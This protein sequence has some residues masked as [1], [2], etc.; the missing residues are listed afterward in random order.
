MNE[1]KI[2]AVNK[3]LHYF[4][5]NNCNSVFICKANHISGKQMMSFRK[6][7]WSIGETFGGKN[8]LLN[9]FL[10]K[11]FLKKIDLKGSYIAII[12]KDFFETLSVI[13][14]FIKKMN[15][16]KNFLLNFSFFEN[17]FY[18]EKKIK[19]INNYENVL[20]VQIEFIHSLNALL[21]KFTNLLNFIKN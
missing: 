10:E 21:V 16:N 2:N 12:S 18:D 11:K 20:H 5:N 15:L 3:M 1:E 17:Y 14:S 6:N 7:I 8:T 9:I 19:L 13:N 4:E